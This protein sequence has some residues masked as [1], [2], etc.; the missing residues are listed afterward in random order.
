MAGIT[1]EDKTTRALVT[2]LDGLTARQRAISNNLANVDTPGF[3]AS[4]VSFARQLDR[5]LQA[6]AGLQ[7]VR[8]DAQHLGGRDEPDNVQITT[9][10]DTS[11]R[12]DGNNVDI[13]KEMALM[14]ETV[15]HFQATTQMV[16]RRLS[17]LRTVINEGRR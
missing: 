1:L 10:S 9:R 14:A 5:A 12:L 8:T 13:D 11:H 17:L 16:S 4:D 15:I 7:M 6:D 2:A 3:K